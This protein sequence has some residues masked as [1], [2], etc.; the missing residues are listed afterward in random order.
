MSDDEFRKLAASL[1]KDKARRELKRHLHD[2]D[3]AL[4]QPGII[5]K[6]AAVFLGVGTA[7]WMFDQFIN[8]IPG[9]EFVPWIFG[10]VVIGWSLQQWGLRPVRRLMRWRADR[11]AAKEQKKLT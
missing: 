2:D 9:I 4:E 11:A 7:M 8:V 3:D 10:S 5:K 1:A 6:G